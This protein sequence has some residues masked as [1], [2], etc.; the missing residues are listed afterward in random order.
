M[1]HGPSR[2]WGGS[3][4]RPELLDTITDEAVI[5]LISN[6]HGNRGELLQWVLAALD[7]DCDLDAG[8][9]TKFQ[10]L[11]EFVVNT[12]GAGRYVVLIIDEAQ[13]LSMEGLEEL[14]MLTN[15]NSNKDEL[16]QLVLV[17]QPELR[18]MI[19]RPELRQFAQRVSASYHLGPMD[20]ETTAEY[21]RHRLRHAGG[22]GDEFSEGAI[23]L[24]HK[25]AAGVPRM[26][27]KI[28]DFAMVYAVTADRKDIDAQIVKNVL[29]DGLFAP[30]PEVV[31]DAA[32]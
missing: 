1:R 23:S 16:L 8:Y 27:N 28:C 15:I 6:A 32:E 11:Q 9:V 7:V 12:Y 31:G 3:V 17:G 2:K 21:I 22:T 20:L 18:E 13:Q 30:M 14:R 5:G 10:L 19:M 29:D 25:N 24:V 4:R 26:V